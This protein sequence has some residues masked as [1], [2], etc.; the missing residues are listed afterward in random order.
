MKITILY[1]IMFYIMEIPFREV[2][3]I[4]LEYGNT[5]ANQKAFLNLPMLQTTSCEDTG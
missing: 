5:V 4:S 1:Y 2:K 3:S